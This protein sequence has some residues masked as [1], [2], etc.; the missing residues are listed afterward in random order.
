MS[1]IRALRIPTSGP[2]NLINV[3][4][5]DYRTMARTIGATYLEHVRTPLPDVA[6]LVDEEG[7]LADDRQV[8]ITV[9]GTLYRGRVF[10]DVLVFSETDGPEGRDVDHLT[11]EH[12]NVVCDRLG[13]EVPS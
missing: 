1:K 5:G 8:N 9:A 11:D 4:A 3:E 12:L 6:M 7:A 13:I 2:L 10:G